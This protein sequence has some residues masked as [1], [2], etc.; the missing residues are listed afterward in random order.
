MDYAMQSCFNCCIINLKDMLENGTVINGKMIETPKSFQTACT[1]TT[2]IIAQV[3]SAQLG[4][5]SI[6]KIDTILAP[7]VRKSY[8]KYLQQAKDEQK[9]YGML[10]E[11]LAEKIA[12]DRTRLEVRAG[13]QTMQ[14]Q[15][16]TL[17]TSNGQSPFCTFL[18]HFEEDYEYAK[19]AA[20][21]TE[22]ILRQ[23][24]QGVKNEKGVY[25][26]PT[27][28]KLIYVLDEHNIHDDSEYRY[29][30]DLAIT[31]SAKRMY[32]DY[33]SAKKMKEIYEG[34]VFAPMG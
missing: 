4:G 14:Y 26:T 22:E 3:A 34:N 31:C 9:L 33:I 21:I 19:E 32:P 7:Y 25:V 28:P 27:F 13:C 15:I 6:N 17:Q 23:R 11:S 10:N 29:L 2:Q 18:M 5:Q 24:Y 8:L 1:I 30:T 16:N 20:M 12:W